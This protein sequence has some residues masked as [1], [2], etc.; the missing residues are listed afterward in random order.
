[1]PLQSYSTGVLSNFLRQRTKAV[2]RIQQH[3]KANETLWNWV[4]IILY[5]C[6]CQ[7]LVEVHFR[8]A[9]TQRLQKNAMT[10]HN[11]STQQQPNM[12]SMGQ[13]QQQ[14][15][16]SPRAPAWYK[17][18]E[19]FA[20]VQGSHNPGT[21]TR[22]R[23]A[24]ADAATGEAS[25]L[26]IATAL[27]SSHPQQSKEHPGPPPE[28]TAL[29]LLWLT[30]AGSTWSVSSCQ[31]S[32]QQ[33][34][35]LQEEWQAATT[36]RR[37]LGAQTDCQWSPVESNGATRRQ[38]AGGTASMCAGQSG[39]LLPVVCS[40]SQPSFCNDVKTQSWDGSVDSGTCCG[41]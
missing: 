9:H 11:A 34:N 16:H 33:S 26:P 13:Q 5:I 20:S 8:P 29:C 22:S 1:M 41:H 3:Y 14:R 25:N 36:S 21:E 40:H 6:F 10:H 28:L 39:V 7:Y 15:R 23:Q 24:A 4:L 31:E 27:V 38:Q 12:N 35:C 17:Q 19:P 30:P 37:A 32:A 2:H 18:P